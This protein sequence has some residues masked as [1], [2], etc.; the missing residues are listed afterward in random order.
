M[1][2]WIAWKKLKA[3][4]YK[5]MVWDELPVFGFGERKKEKKL[6]YVLSFSYKIF[7]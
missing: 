2:L 7:E 6:S 5:L 4:D 3:Q 1:K